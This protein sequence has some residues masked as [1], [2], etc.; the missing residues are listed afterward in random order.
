LVCVSRRKRGRV[1][2]P[3]GHPSMNCTAH[4][5]FGMKSLLKIGRQGNATVFISIAQYAHLGYLSAV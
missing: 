1:G 4:E 3:A 2:F 5:Q